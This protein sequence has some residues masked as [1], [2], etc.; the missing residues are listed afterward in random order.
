MAFV[1][2]IAVEL[3]DGSWL[4]YSP[5]PDEEIDPSDKYAIGAFVVDALSRVGVSTYE[6]KQI[7]AN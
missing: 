7:I 3:H 6:I 5:F 1:E 4:E 2:T